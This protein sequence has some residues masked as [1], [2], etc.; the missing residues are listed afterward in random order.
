LFQTSFVAEFARIRAEKPESAYQDNPRPV[1][2]RPKIF[3]PTKNGPKRKSAL[4]RLACEASLE[5]NS[6]A[7]ED[8]AA[9]KFG[10]IRRV[11]ALLGLFVP[12]LVTPLELLG[13]SDASEATE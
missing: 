7:W 2:E 6:K 13:G 11:N 3:P 10:H 9:N 8:R 5:A 4:D 1:S 12:A